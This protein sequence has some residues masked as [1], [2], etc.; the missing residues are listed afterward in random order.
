MAIIGND[1]EKAKLLSEKGEL[2]A[3]PTET[4]YGLAANAFNAD[5]VLKIYE[6]KD[7]PKFNPLIIHSNSLERFEEWGIVIPE[8]LKRL[9]NK[10]SPVPVVCIQ[11]TGSCC[12]ARTNR[13][14]LSS[15]LPL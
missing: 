3:I 8:K 15:G 13:M 5:A 1:I 7:R 2:V 4:V 12:P 9:A 11:A 10:F 14:Y 6:V